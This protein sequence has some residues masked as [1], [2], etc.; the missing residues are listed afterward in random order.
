M[1]T[2]LDLGPVTASTDIS[3]CDTAEQV[4]PPEPGEPTLAPAML[5]STQNW[6]EENFSHVH[7]Q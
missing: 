4:T 5:H 7:E 2:E 3:P 1:Q 6:K